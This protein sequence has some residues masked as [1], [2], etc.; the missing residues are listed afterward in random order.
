[1]LDY[2]HANYARS[3]QLGDL[4]NSVHLR[5]SY[6][7]YLFSSTVGVTFHHYLEQLRLTKAKNLLRDPVNRVSEVAY[8]VGYT[9][10]NH[11]RN[12][13]T[14]RVGIPPS[15]WRETSEAADVGS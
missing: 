12:V 10:P 13:F 15:A 14:A 6:A 1:M 7:C 8:A 9:N 2:I 3:I 11:F 4:A 5:T